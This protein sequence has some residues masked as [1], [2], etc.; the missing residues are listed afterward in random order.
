MV[1][2]QS[3]IAIMNFDIAADSC[4]LSFSVINQQIL[5]N[6]NQS[7]ATNSVDYS[8]HLLS[9]TL[10]ISIQHFLKY[11][12][13]IK[14]ESSVANA[15]NS[16]GISSGNSGTG[17]S[18]L[19]SN[20]LNLGMDANGLNGSGFNLKASDLLGLK[21]GIN[22][23]MGSSSSL[24]HS[25]HHHN[26]HHGDSMVNGQ[27]STSTAQ[28]TSSVNTASNSTMN[29]TSIECAPATTTTGSSKKKKKK[30][31]KE[32]K[33]RPKPGEIR[34]TKALDGSTLY[35]CPEW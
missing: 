1:N 13:T 2:P 34:E 6:V 27:P 35:C 16:N 19:S 17:I 4:D 32:R 3:N 28:T 12:E 9:A 30:A 8:S 20:N 11:S 23:P 25:Q 22:H 33:P 21:N 31:P 18:P 26:H 5:Q 15:N 29:Q 14:K 7:W 24:N 10:P